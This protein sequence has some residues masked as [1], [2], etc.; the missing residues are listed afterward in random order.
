MDASGNTADNSSSR[1]L[2]NTQRETPLSSNLARRGAASVRKG[3]KTKTERII[4]TKRR[5]KILQEQFSTQCHKRRQTGIHILRYN[6]REMRTDKPFPSGP[7]RPDVASSRPRGRKLR[8]ARGARSQVFPQRGLSGSPKALPSPR[9]RRHRRVPPTGF[10][11]PFSLAL[12]APSRGGKLGPARG[13]RRQ[14][15]SSTRPA[16]FPEGSIPLAPGRG[17]HRQV[18]S[19]RVR[20]TVL[21]PPRPPASSVP[22][23]CLRGLLVPFWPM[24]LLLPGPFRPFSEKPKSLFEGN[25]LRKRKRKKHFRKKGFGR[26]GS[27]ERK[28]S[29]SLDPKPLR[30]RRRSSPA[31]PVDLARFG[32]WR[33]CSPAPF[34]ESLFVSVDLAPV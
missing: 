18:S 23:V 30:N 25:T 14:A 28:E 27:P 3:K 33:F 13:A 22:G 24:V 31:L 2:S 1:R 6:Y 16:R 8:T 7:R 34:R 12:V 17:G 29:T 10:A 32:L 9:R 26:V 20:E 15:C 5:R 21:T 11:K 19:D 4:H